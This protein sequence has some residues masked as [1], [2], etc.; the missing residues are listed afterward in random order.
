MYIYILIHTHIYMYTYICVCVFAYTKKKQ[1]KDKHHKIIV[2]Y[3]GGK[4]WNTKDGNKT[5]TPWIYIVL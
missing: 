1:W 2:T 5:R 3:K 4:K